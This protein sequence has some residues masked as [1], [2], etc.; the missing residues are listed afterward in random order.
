M[1]KITLT[2]GELVSLAQ[3]GVLA[4]FLTTP[5]PIKIGWENRKIGPTA[6]TELKAYNDKRLELLKEVGATLP[7]GAKE[8]VFPGTEALE[9]FKIELNEL[10]AQTVDLPGMPVN[11]SDLKGDLSESDLNLLEKFIKD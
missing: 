5:K 6:D 10:L 7:E 9:K 4:K 8:Y 2:I 11:F 1:N 3:T